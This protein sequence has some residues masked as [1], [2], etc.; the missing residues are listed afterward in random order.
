MHITGSREESWEEDQADKAE[1]H[2]YSDRS[3]VDGYAGKAAVLYRD[4]QAV[5]S[6]RYFLSP[7]SQHTT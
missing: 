1:V 3:G 5:K 7:L 2:A 6:L 4:G